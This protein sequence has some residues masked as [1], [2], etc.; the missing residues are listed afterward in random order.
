MQYE[1]G[2]GRTIPGAV[3]PKIYLHSSHLTVFADNIF[4]THHIASAPLCMHTL[5][6][7]R[8]CVNAKIRYYIY[9][10]DASITPGIV[11]SSRAS[12]AVFPPIPLEPPCRG[13]LE[14]WKTVRLS[15]SAIAKLN[16][17]RSMFREGTRRQQSLCTSIRPLFKKSYHSPR[18]C[19]KGS[20]QRR[21]LGSKVGNRVY[22][23]A[24][25]ILNVVDSLKSP[26]L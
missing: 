7:F 13:H 1:I 25:V 16:A 9:I 19:T 21:C 6:Q 20:P 23:E 26:P 11:R 8:T 10:F 22:T 12:C 24:A 3:P 18:K 17:N 5:C 15:Y 2:N 4:F 14:G